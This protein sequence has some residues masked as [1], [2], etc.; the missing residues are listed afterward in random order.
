MRTQLLLGALGTFLVLAGC[1]SSTDA[2]TDVDEGETRIEPNGSDSP[3]KLSVTLPSG[4][5]EA[6]TFMWRTTKKPVGQVID[7]LPVGEQDFTLASGGLNTRGRVTI[8]AGQTTT[9]Q[10]ALVAIDAV[11]GPRTLGLA[12]DPTGYAIQVNALEPALTRGSVGSVSPTSN[13]SSGVALLA[14]NYE[15]NFGVGGYDGVPVKVAAGATTKA[16]LTDT[17][18]RRVVRIKAP[19]REMPTAS[20]GGGDP[21]LY[22]IAIPG[23]NS[24]VE[25]AMA[26]SAELDVGAAPSKPMAKYELT[27]SAWSR[28]VPL[29]LPVASQGL[30]T[31]ALGR[32][33][34][35][36]VLINATQ[37]RVPGTY[38]IYQTDASGN[39]GAP[40][41]R[42]IPKTKTGV[43]LPPGKYRIEVTYNT[44][45]AGDKIDVH[46]LTVP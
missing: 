4:A 32:V 36:D 13:G 35:E 41:L 19:V 42:C 23:S 31:L 15:V 46:Q 7:S 12:K 11:A 33:D 16:V 26:D 25:A 37:P 39:R 43:D 40:M 28:A 6:T 10:A 20:C 14:G 22:R 44:V 29:P 27:A 24:S 1:S 8:A 18:Q 3:G 2:E 34:I 30:S 9:V 21:N 45:E 17:S 38:Q 5:A